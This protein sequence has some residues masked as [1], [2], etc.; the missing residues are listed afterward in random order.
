MDDGESDNNHYCTA[1][2]IP[3]E[4]PNHYKRGSFHPV[5]LGDCFGPSGCYRVFNKLGFGG[6][7]TV[8]LCRDTLEG[9]WRALKIERA[10]D[11]K[12]PVRDGYR[13]LMI[14][15]YL[16]LTFDGD[17]PSHHIGMPSE[18]FWISGPNG[19]HL[20]GVMPVLGPTVSLVSEYYGLHLNVLK[21]IG[22]QL[23]Q[24]LQSLHGHGICH[25]DFRPANTLFQLADDIDE[26]SPR[27]FKF[28][29]RHLLLQDCR[30][31]LW[32]CISRRDPPPRNR[33]FHS[34]SPPPKSFWPSSPSASA[35]IYGPLPVLCRWCAAATPHSANGHIAARPSVL[36]LRPKIGSLTK[37]LD[38]ERLSSQYCGYDQ[39]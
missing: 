14:K 13:E 36:W 10:Y 37:R 5:G 38:R 32:C 15:Q 28:Q 4:D 7:G 18:Y 27:R 12:K 33:E 22:F 11:Q 24:S 25:G 35:R 6:C 3:T 23:A 17:L 1:E 19:H 31:R 26:W 21:D 8:W 16:D 9:K 30:H 2:Y 20:C 29:F 39:K 34:P